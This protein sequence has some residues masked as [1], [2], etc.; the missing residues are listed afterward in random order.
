MFF[1]L[2]QTLV[3]GRSVIE[4]W[5]ICH[6]TIYCSSTSREP[7][8]GTTDTHGRG[9]IC[10]RYRALISWFP[11]VNGYLIIWI[12]YRAWFVSI[13]EYIHR[14]DFM[15]NYFTVIF[16]KNPKIFFFAFCAF[17]SCPRFIEVHYLPQL[18]LFF[19]FIGHMAVCM[20]VYLYQGQTPMSEAGLASELLARCRTYEP[21]RG[22][23]FIYTV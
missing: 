3:L 1:R 14:V 17:V 8:S 22:I 23:S 16:A 4:I 18:F 10:L 21:L 12:L 5:P 19:F 2:L 11:V 13:I 9:G 7:H 15:K 6:T 20:L